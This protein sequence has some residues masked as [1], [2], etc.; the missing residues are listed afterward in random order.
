LAPRAGQHCASDLRAVEVG[1]LAP[2]AGQH[3][4]SD[5]RDYLLFYLQQRRRM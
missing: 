3:G 2:R 1:A 4:A 5:L